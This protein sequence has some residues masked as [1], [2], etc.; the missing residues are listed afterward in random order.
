MTCDSTCLTKLI[1]YYV[2]GN[3]ADRGLHRQGPQRG[4]AVGAPPGGGVLQEHREGQ[5][6]GLPGPALSDP[7]LTLDCITD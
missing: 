5:H 1:P 2:A 6:Q 7:N 4:A 3:Q